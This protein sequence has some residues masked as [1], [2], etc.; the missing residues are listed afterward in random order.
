MLYL[1]LLVILLFG[2]SAVHMTAADC[3]VGCDT[4][5]EPVCASDNRTYRNLCIMNLES[6]I[7]RQNVTVVSYGECP[8]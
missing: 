7:Y 5:Y 2:G 6:C 4:E 1:P 8:W 3:D